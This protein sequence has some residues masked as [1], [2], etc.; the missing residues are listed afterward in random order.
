MIILQ[1][2][3]VHAI[4]AMGTDLEA[5]QKLARIPMEGADKKLCIK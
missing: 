3:V 4:I 1:Y 5:T 2:R